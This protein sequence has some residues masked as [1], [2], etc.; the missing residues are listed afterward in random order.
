MKKTRGQAISNSMTSQA[1][2]PCMKIAFNYCS[3][4]GE[5]SKPMNSFSVLN[6]QGPC[7]DGQGLDFTEKES[8]YTDK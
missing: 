3:L 7:I 2:D 8:G 5:D 1:G 4:N 6:E